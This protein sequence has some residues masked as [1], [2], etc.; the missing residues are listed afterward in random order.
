MKK[1][2]VLIGVMLLITLSENALEANWCYVDTGVAQSGDG[3]SWKTAFKTLPEAIRKASNGDTILFATNGNYQEALWFNIGKNLAGESVVV[4]EHVACGGQIF[5]QTYDPEGN[6]R[7]EKLWASEN[8]FKWNSQPSA[9]MDSSGNFVVAWISTNDVGFGWKV[10]FRLYDQ[11]ENPSKIF[12]CPGV[13]KPEHQA[14]C[15]RP[16]MA[17]SQGKFAVC[18]IDCRLVQEG[19]GYVPKDVN[20][21]CQQ[22]HLDGETMGE[23]YRINHEAL[24]IVPVFILERETATDEEMRATYQS[25]NS[26]SSGAKTLESVTATDEEIRVTYWRK[27][28]DPS[29][30]KTVISWWQDTKPIIKIEQTGNPGEII[31]LTIS[32]TIVSRKYQVYYCDKIGGCWLPLGEPITASENEVVVRDNWEISLPSPLEVKSR[33][34]RAEILP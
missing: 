12:Q 8:E 11:S 33:F 25:K 5:A 23:I 20:I 22:F 4:W 6:I 10:Y 28:T 15:P 34:Y 1:T 7:G 18:W 2:L 17:P 16:A 21:Y 24:E 9:A 19:F 29:S 27:N 26:D 13:D 30:A 3:A 31:W 14:H 32:P